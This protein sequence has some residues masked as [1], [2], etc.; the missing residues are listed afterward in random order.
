MSERIKGAGSGRS[1]HPN[2]YA[3]GI[4]AAA[5]I[6]AR[7]VERVVGAEGGDDEVEGAGTLQLPDIQV[8]DR[9]AAGLGP[10]VPEVIRRQPS[11]VARI[12]KV[13]LD[14][15][16]AAIEHRLLRR[17]QAGQEE[18]RRRG[19]RGEGQRRTG[20]RGAVG[21]RLPRAKR[22]RSGRAPS[23]LSRCEHTK[24][25]SETPFLPN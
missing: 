5:A 16:G 25:S 7:R 17:T 10:F 13:D 2:V 9:V 3:A 8:A 22:R 14:G 18:Q 24:E 11:A 1:A 15:A 19:P 21:A 12:V 4:A 6:L 23:H 20:H